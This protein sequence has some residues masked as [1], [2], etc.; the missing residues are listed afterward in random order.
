MSF[1]GALDPL[2]EVPGVLATA[3]F[4]ADGQPMTLAGDAA[5]IELAGAYQSVWLEK[6]AAACDQSA[7]G[8]LEELRFDFDRASMYVVR[9]PEG[10]F[11][12]VLMAHGAAV[13]ELKN[14]LT[15]VVKRLAKEMI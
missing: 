6:L 8:N 5:L 3:F 4:D 14:R 12:L 1:R 7:L 13:W 15:G 10:F 9:L 11:I 2:L